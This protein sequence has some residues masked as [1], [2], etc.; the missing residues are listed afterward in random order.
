MTTYTVFDPN[1]SENFKPG[2][3]LADAMDRCMSADNFAYEIRPMNDGG[4]AL[5]RGQFSQ[6]STLGSRPMVKTVMFSLKPDRE[7]AEAEIF[8]EAL[9]HDWKLECMTDEDFAAL[10]AEMAADI[11]AAGAE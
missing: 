11:E 1:D 2:L 3:T 5:W 6:S 4:F 10:Q 8:T 9:S 7:T